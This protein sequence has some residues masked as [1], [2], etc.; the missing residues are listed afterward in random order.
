MMR[1]MYAAV[2]GLRVHQTKM[3]VIGN[4]IA[5][6]NTVGY[7]KGQVTFQ[8]AFNEVI[9]GASGA[10]DGKGGTNPQQIGL[11]VN[12]GSM[13]TIHTPGASQRT[14]NPTDLKIEGNGYFM[15]SGDKDL[16]TKYY[17][18]AGNFVFDEA[19]NLV[20]PNGM[21]V[22]AKYNGSK[23]YADKMGIDINKDLDS[24]WVSKTIM[25]PASATTKA[26][27]DGNLN[28]SKPTFDYNNPKEE[29][30]VYKNFSI[31][32]SLG[33]DYTINLAF[34]KMGANSWDYH[35]TSIDGPG[36]V[37]VNTP[38]ITDPLDEN[39]SSQGGTVTF[40]TDGSM[41]IDGSEKFSLELSG[42]AGSY[43]GEL[44]DKNDPSTATNTISIDLSGISQVKGESE[45]KSEVNGRKAGKVTGYSI[46][47]S[48][49]VVASFSNGIKESLWR[50][51]LANFDNPMG[52]EKIGGNLYDVSANS[53]DP[54]T[55][56]PNSGSFGKV[57][58]GV[59]EMSNVDL[60]NEFTEMI[61]TQ[62][63][64]QANSRVITTTDEML[65]ELVNLKR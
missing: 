8:E 50:I 61:T 16:S 13:N 17:T 29:E 5:N 40:N 2:S 53:G 43:F 32:D 34:T 28:S 45:L 56:N 14:D 52:L 51:Q 24:V 30:V 25:A 57:T 11:G 55:G 35:V 64:F 31:K 12:M 62:R 23:E 21:K 54:N 15:V 7:K 33:N 38:P 41:N 65:Q 46:N 18:R 3:D 59:L 4:N 19:G 6:V 49:E 60:S 36:S 1:S 58:A 63:G 22:L 39:T 27:L 48:G 37:T 9:R 42:M 44:T 20:T 47:A 26:E 10:Q